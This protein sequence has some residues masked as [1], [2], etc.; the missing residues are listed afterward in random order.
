MDEPPSIHLLIHQFIIQ[1][2]RIYVNSNF[3]L[4]VHQLLFKQKKSSMQKSV[5]CSSIVL[6]TYSYQI[7]GT[8]TKTDVILYRYECI[9]SAFHLK[10]AILSKGNHISALKLLIFMQAPLIVNVHTFTKDWKLPTSIYFF[11]L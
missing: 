5:E 3:S 11:H 9:I 8:R 2:F 1:C 6:C 4:K 7:V 10:V